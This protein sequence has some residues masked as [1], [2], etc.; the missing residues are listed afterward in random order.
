MFNMNHFSLLSLIIETKTNHSSVH[1]VRSQSEQ[2][3][4]MTDALQEFTCNIIIPLLPAEAD[5]FL[6]ILLV[7]PSCVCRFI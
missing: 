2:C 4:E 5:V 3:S 1:Q 7:L 6:F